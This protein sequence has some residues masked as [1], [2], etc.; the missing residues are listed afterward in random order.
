MQERPPVIQRMLERIGFAPF[1]AAQL[2]ALGPDLTA[3]RIAIDHGE[4]YV[5]WTGSGPC[6]AL[7]TGRHN[8]RRAAVERPQVGDWVAG[9]MS[10]DL[11]AFI[12]E[13]RLERRTC[14]SRQGA[15]DRPE[16]QVIAAN[17]D[18]VGVVSALGD[19]EAKQERWLV[20]E[21]RIARYLVA[22]AESGARPLIVLN[23]SDLHPDASA[24]AAQLEQR[25]AGIPVLSVSAAGA[26]GLERLTG[27]LDPGATLVLVGMSGVG[28]STLVNA[29]LGR[30]TQRVGDVRATDA[31]G[32]HT[33]THRELFMLPAGGLLID[34]PGMR[35]MTLWEGA[36]GGE[37]RRSRTPYRRQRRR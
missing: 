21:S 35:E 25:F 37:E 11:S 33:T 1:F 23:K 27:L 30:D 16:R 26:V 4:S 9:A 28:K 6:K 32:R 22:V 2:D 31:R 20:N 18:M 3:A 14:L 19:G 12:V 10:P 24:V 15:A 17:A 8:E 13:H 34:T 7:I 29:L 36:T 5:A